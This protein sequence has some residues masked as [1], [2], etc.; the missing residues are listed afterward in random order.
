MC[1]K[2]IVA[3]HD[4]RRRR[5][6]FDLSLSSVIG[7]LTVVYPSRICSYYLYDEY[8]FASILIWKNCK[9]LE[10]MIN[11]NMSTIKQC[12]INSTISIDNKEDSA[13]MKVVIK[14]SVQRIRLWI[15]D[16]TFNY[17][18]RVFKKDSVKVTLSPFTYFS[19]IGRY[20]LDRI[21]SSQISKIPHLIQL[22]SSSGCE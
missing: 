6:R 17:Q 5:E 13:P 15:I 21:F 12:I 8:A 1:N 19:C 14:R 2:A 16:F 11:R 22:Y 4:T 20:S 3:T 7:Y 18:L 10:F 9:W